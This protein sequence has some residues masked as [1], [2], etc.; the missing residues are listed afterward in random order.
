MDAYVREVRTAA[1]RRVGALVRA[2]HGHP[3]VFLHG[4]LDSS[5]GWVSTIRA[6]H[7]PCY[8]LDLPGF[9]RSERAERPELETYAT[10]V[11][12]ALDALG[13]EAFTLVGH[14]LGGAVAAAVTDQAPGR[15]SALALLAPAGF[16]RIALA[17]AVSVPV[18]RQLAAAALPLALS[19]PVAITA[20]Y[21]TMVTNKLPPAREIVKRTMRS[22]GRATPGAVDATKAIVSAGRDPQGFAYR[23]VW[24][25]GPVGVLWGDRD[26]L[27]PISHL[28]GVRRAFPQARVTVWEGMG[29]HPQ[30]E[31]PSELARFIEATCARAR[32]H[33]RRR[34]RERHRRRATELANAA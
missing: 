1:G 8:A 23:R 20:A 28:R 12:D 22:A 32:T 2:G 14:S 19:N 33:R 11:L 25:D 18:V 7:R 24:Y 4:L 3:V 26:R 5:A 27:V 29:H 15:V 6:T 30:A 17:E 21:M 16:G 10:A 34:R 9:G 13:V 31:R